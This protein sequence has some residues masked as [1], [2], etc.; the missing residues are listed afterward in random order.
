M[1]T[2]PIVSA[3]EPYGAAFVDRLMTTLG[4]G[5]P[6]VVSP[7]ERSEIAALVSTMSIEQKASLTTGRDMWH[8]QAVPEHGIA[9]WRMTD[10]PNGARGTMW[11]PAGV[12]ALCMPTGIALA[13]TWDVALVRA[14][15]GALG[16]E[17]RARAAR[18]MLAPTI[19]IQRSPLNGRTFECLS[20]DPLLAGR[21]AAALVQGIQS[22]GVVATMKHFAG[23]EA[24][25]ERH[26][27]NSV[28]DER[29]LREIYLAPFEMAV[30][31]GGALGVMTAY[32][33]LN[34]RFPAD[35]AWLI[36]GVLRK[37]WGFEGI[38]I[39]DW[40]ALCDTVDAANAGL[41]IEMPGPGR[42]FGG[43]LAAAVEE[44]RVCS[45]KLDAIAQRLLAVMTSIGARN[46][47]SDGQ[48]FTLDDPEAGA[49]A[50]RASTD[51]MVLIRNEG[52]LL[53]VEVRS[54]RRVALLGPNAH[55]SQI[56]G[57]GSSIL[58]AQ[59]RTSILSALQ[60]A[61]GEA[62]VEILFEEGV[63]GTDDFIVLDAP[64]LRTPSGET[65]VEV[66]FFIGL[67]PAGQ[68]TTVHRGDSLEFLFMGAPAPRVP[69]GAF[70]L[71]AEASFVAM[72]D[73]LHSFRLS[74]GSAARLE[75]DGQLHIDLGDHDFIGKG[76]ERVTDS[77]IYLTAGQSIR[78]VLTYFG[79]T[80]LGF[81]HVSL[82]CRRPCRPDAAA[83]AARLAADADM[84]IV[85][86]G[87]S[88]LTE[89]EGADRKGLELPEG[90]DELIE[91]VAAANPRTVVVINS[92]GPVS[93]PWIA[94]VPAVLQSWFGGQEMAAALADVLLGASEPGGRMPI[95]FPERIEHSPAFGN[96]P[97][98]AG[99]L[100]YGEGLLVGYRWY[101]ARHLPRL[102][103]FGHGLGYGSL[104]WSQAALS[105]REVRAGEAVTVSLL[106]ENVGERAGSD[107]IQ[108]YVEPP[109]GPLMRAPKELQGFA[110][111]RLEPGSSQRVEIELDARRFSTWHPGDQD[112]RAIHARLGP[113]PF[114]KLGDMTDHGTG[115]MIHPGIYVIHVAR[116]SVEVVMSIPLTIIEQEGP[117]P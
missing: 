66:S 63:P 27:M 79:D 60:S 103:P 71:R 48:E 29:S 83:Q 36:E 47:Q 44:G 3:A 42:A 114:S 74:T 15:G 87:T 76:G 88:P 22:E 72:V 41:D 108:I 45:A 20:E 23:N 111:L 81:S 30:K 28:I 4:A 86:V 51:A 9:S 12:R 37:E 106:V 61:F 26:A 55:R 91:Q 19:N 112:S 49:L 38:A 52:A 24:E 77:E 6:R 56:M 7:E 53:P 85:V 11:G 50:K 65:G 16:R 70:S 110:K 21:L 92:G 107:V 73:G 109:A 14:V 2:A 99:E 10:G 104:Q 89:T 18:I 67:E 95:T 117:Q 62:G 17:A 39:T 68:P 46:D 1:T 78:M 94:K 84:A 105:A 59:H 96:F 43:A 102:V 25:Y 100:R 64:D 75:L 90:Q 98:E 8:T 115:W 33:R 58:R 34:G 13:A 57:G 80:A 93:M 69:S 40:W 97:G 116:S 5:W 32:N 54:L 35:S 101:E 113:T 31:E 82:R